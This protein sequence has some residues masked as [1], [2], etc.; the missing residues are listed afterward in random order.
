MHCTEVPYV[1]YICTVFMYCIIASLRLFSS[2]FGSHGL[3]CVWQNHLTVMYHMHNEIRYFPVLT[4]AMRTKPARFVSNTDESHSPVYATC[5]HLRYRQLRI[6]VLSIVLSTVVLHGA[7]RPHAAKT[8]GTVR[9]TIR[10]TRAADCNF[11]K[12]HLVLDCLDVASV[13][14][15]LFLRIRP[16]VNRRP[17]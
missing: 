17:P 1:L 14:D 3:N 6:A 8:T 7:V 16:P 11:L 4:I 5:A 13:S 12:R 10:S 15:Q 2:A 9:Q